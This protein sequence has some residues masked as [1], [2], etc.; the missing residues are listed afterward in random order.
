MAVVPT[1]PSCRTTC[2]VLSIYKAEGFHTNTGTNPTRRLVVAAG[3]RS[4]RTVFPFGGAS[5]QP[6]S[7]ESVAGPSPASPRRVCLPGPVGG[8]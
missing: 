1:A 4:A 5:R 6:L 8:R 2:M 3:L 7:F